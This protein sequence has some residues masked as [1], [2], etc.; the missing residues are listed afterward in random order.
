MDAAKIRED[1]QRERDVGRLVA[2][3]AIRLGREI[4]CVRLDHHAVIGDDRCSLANRRGIF[5]RD[6]SRERDA[7]SQREELARRVGITCEAMDHA[8]AR[9][10]AA[11]AHYLD[12]AALCIAAMDHD[13]QIEFC[14]KREMR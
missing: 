5:E 9:W 1:V 4:G 13:W 3:A 10:N 2:F 8:A 12:E 6:D 7:K 11:L 14:G